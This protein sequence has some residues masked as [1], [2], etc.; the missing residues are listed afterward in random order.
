[1]FGLKDLKN[2]KYSPFQGKVSTAITSGQDWFEVDVKIMFGDTSIGLKDIKK[3]ILNQQKYVQLKDGSVGLLPKEWFHKLEKYFRHGEIVGDKL[4]VSKLRFGIIDELFDNISDETVLNEIAEKRQRMAQFT[5]ITKTEVPQEITAD[6]RSYQ[7]E[8]LNWLNFL[9]EMGWGGI[10]A[11]D[12]GLGK[13]IQV[14]TF[15]QHLV[16]KDSKPNLV[17]V[18]TTLLFNWENELKKFAPE[19]KAYYHYG[20]NRERENF[21]F[22]DYNI[23]FTGYGVLLP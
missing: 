1:M 3:A 10:L 18:P 15:L 22:E 4:A 12:M 19:L 16:K 5:E 23:V 6:L 2:F 14:L 21:V 20:V 17:V 8:G 7:K 13:T 11:D 9:D